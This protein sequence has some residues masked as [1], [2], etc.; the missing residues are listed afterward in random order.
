MV[1]KRWS[2]SYINDQIDGKVSEFNLDLPLEPS[3]KI[4]EFDFLNLGKK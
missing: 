1:I 4:Y 2:T 3:M